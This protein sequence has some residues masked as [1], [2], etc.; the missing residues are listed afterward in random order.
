MTPRNGA[1][2]YSCPWTSA[3]EAPGATLLLSKIHS[4]IIF[5][6][7]K[8][9]QSIPQT[10]NFHFF[11]N[12]FVTFKEKTLAKINSEERWSYTVGYTVS[13]VQCRYNMTHICNFVFSSSHILKI[14]EKLVKWILTMCFISP[15]IDK[16]YLS[17]QYLVNIF[18]LLMRCFTFFSLNHVFEIW[19]VFYTYSISQ[20][21]L[22]TL[23]VLHNHRRLVACIM[24][25]TD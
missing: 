20:I 18:K 4:S 12:Q 5:W 9:L 6:F 3:A 10:F 11:Q 19:G 17:F 22:A 23:W 21:R 16:Y 15:N 1:E 2:W 13:M 24:D 25:S 8:S 7:W 14:E